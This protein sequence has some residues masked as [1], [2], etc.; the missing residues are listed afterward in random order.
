MYCCC[1][2]W[3]RSLSQSESR[4]S[5]EHFLLVCY[6]REGKEKVGGGS[7]RD[8]TGAWVEKTIFCLEGSQSV[9]TSPSKGKASR[10]VCLGIGPPLGQMT[11]F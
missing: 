4:G 5:L 6:R 11:R 7:E 1:W 9:S 8:Y 10:P 3:K 2:A